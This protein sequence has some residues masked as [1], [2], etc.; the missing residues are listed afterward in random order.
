MDDTS[1]LLK[2]PAE[3]GAA[4]AFEHGRIVGN[5]YEIKR[6][7]GRGGMGEVWLAFDL[8][9][10]VDVALKVLLS[11]G[12]GARL[13]HQEIRAAREVISPNVCRVFD[14]V[15]AD[16]LELLSMEFVD[17]ITLRQHLE[18]HSPLEFFEAQDVAAQFLAGL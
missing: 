1:T 7:L 8:R 11:H 16:G 5:R 13:L 4:L 15:E 10:R 9:L 14:L 18:Q 3:E 12:E 17:G 6:R 2:P